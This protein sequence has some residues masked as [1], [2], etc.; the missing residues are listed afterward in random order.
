MF[1]VN[2]L[3]LYAHNPLLH[4]VTATKLGKV[5]SKRAENMTEAGVKLPLVFDSDIPFVGKS[6]TDDVRKRK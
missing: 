2:N 5:V 1:G 3:V 6:F 4:S